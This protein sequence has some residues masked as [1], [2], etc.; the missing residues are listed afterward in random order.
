MML[1]NALGMICMNRLIKNAKVIYFTN[2]LN[3]SENNPKKMW[4]T[5]NKLTNKKSKATLISE[6]RNGYQNLTNKHEI[7]KEAWGI[8]N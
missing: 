8:H 3:D 7:F 6:I 1:I 5:I 4:K 2:T